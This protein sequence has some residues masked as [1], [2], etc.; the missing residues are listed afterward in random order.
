MCLIVSAGSSE[1][2]SGAKDGHESFPI[3]IE[4]FASSLSAVAS[5]AASRTL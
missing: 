5:F 2:R 1:Y 4:R 3:K